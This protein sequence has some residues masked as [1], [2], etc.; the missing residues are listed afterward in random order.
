MTE[1]IIVGKWSFKNGKVLKDDNC[2]L[3]EEMIKN[4]FEEVGKSSDGWDI[5]YQD[6]NSGDFWKLTYP[7][8]HLH[9][10]GPPKLIKLDKY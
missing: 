10:G 4:Q 7:E 3:I 8:S 1:S 2:L 9:G 6:K 5:I